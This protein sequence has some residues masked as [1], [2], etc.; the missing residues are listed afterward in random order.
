M[1]RDTHPEIEEAKALLNAAWRTADRRRFNKLLEWAR[2]TLAPL[3]QQNNGPAMWMLMSIPDPKSKDVSH[4]VF[5]R[6][7]RRHAE[8]AAQNG[9]AEAMFFLGCELDNEEERRES[10]AYFEK[11]AGLG[12]TYSKWCFGLNLLSGQ[13]T[14]KDEARG[15]AFIRQAAEEKFEGAIQFV[16]R[17]YEQGSYGFPKQED[18]AAVWWSKLKD[19][20]V[21]HY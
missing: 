11:A 9:S 19:K 16:S 5:E 4:E 2:K 1:V 20:D 7:H 18:L 10:S 15:V 17:A 14:L 3:S 21:I 8:Q 13:G 12:H 6:E